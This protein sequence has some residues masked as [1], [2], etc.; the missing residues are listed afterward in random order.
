M[1][2][3]YKF[4]SGNIPG[5]LFVLIFGLVIVNLVAYLLFKK[6]D[7]FEKPV[8][9]KRS[10]LLNLLV[11][12]LYF[13][14][15]FV[16]QPRQLPKTVLIQPFQQG[17]S[18]DVTISEMVEQNLSG[19]ISAKFRLH[20]W[21]WFYLT[22]DKDSINSSAYRQSL[23]ARLNIDVVV[24]GQI[25]GTADNL[26]LD[27]TIK[28]SNKIIKISSNQVSGREA[29]QE[30]IRQLDSLI[31]ILRNKQSP[32]TS[33]AEVDYRKLT[34]AKLAYLN[35]EYDLPL[36]ILNDDTLYAYRLIMSRALL[37]KALEQEKA[38]KSPAAMSAEELNPFFRR[39]ERILKPYSIKGVDTA[40]LNSILGQMYLFRNEYE[41][42]DICLKKAITQNRYDARLFYYLSFLDIERLKEIK[43][44]D[45]IDILKYAIRLDPGYS[46]CVSRLANDVYNRGSGTSQART[47]YEAIEIMENYLKLNAN[48]VPILR[49][50]GR[51]YLQIK[52][53]PRATVLFEK[54]LTLEPDSAESYYD[55]GVCYFDDKKYDQAGK[56]LEQAIKIGDHRES[57]L[58]LGAVYFVKGDL[59][60]ALYYYR[61]RI[62]RKMNDD[63]YYALEAMRGVRII[64]ERMQGDS[65]GNNNLDSIPLP[66]L[67]MKGK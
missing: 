20:P 19:N 59:E 65:T 18:I 47:T 7:L 52:N 29:A 31:P 61:E 16:L 13:F 10:I 26:N 37:K 27:G 48:T 8:Y 43:Y 33:E 55:L 50:L 4:L 58:Y 24:G 38:R 64:L 9:K 63:D 34:R 42:A 25:Q 44:T 2:D 51:I 22:A 17:D 5:G 32:M 53:M 15:W 30:I 12:I 62:K 1:N 45:R 60:K 46:E 23:A 39:M 3:I 66:S 11:V 40:E 21:E 54:V 41:I 57:Y 35:G 56:Y 49:L 6:S 67:P 36:Q 14:L 28:Y